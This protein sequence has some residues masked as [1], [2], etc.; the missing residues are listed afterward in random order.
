MPNGDSK[1]LTQLIELLRSAYK[2]RM[3]TKT[4]SPLSVT[5]S[6]EIKPSSDPRQREL[7]ALA[8]NSGH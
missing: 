4:S 7:F 8:N 3:V 5:F 2:E 1:N 6:F